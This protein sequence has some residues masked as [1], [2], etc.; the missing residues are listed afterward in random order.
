MLRHA[1]HLA[2][3]G[4]QDPHPCEPWGRGLQPCLW[5]R[6][7][8]LDR[9]SNASVG[10]RTNLVAKRRDRLALSC[11]GPQALGPLLDTLEKL[12]KEQ[13]DICKELAKADEQIERETIRRPTA[14]EVQSVWTRIVELWDVVPEEDRPALLGAIVKRVEVVRAVS[15]IQMSRVPVCGSQVA[16]ATRFSSGERDTLLCE[17]IAPTKLNNLPVRSNQVSWLRAP[18]FRQTRTPSSETE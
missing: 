5:Q 3:A 7:F 15:M 12:E 2:H 10:V 4:L 11:S 16:T 8:L 6:R 9:V 1:E 18:A 13:I 14:E 17:P